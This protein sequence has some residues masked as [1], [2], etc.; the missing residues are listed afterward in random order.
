MKFN[1][2][3]KVQQEFMVGDSAFI[4]NMFGGA[5]LKQISGK[6]CE[7]CGRIKLRNLLVET[8]FWLRSITFVICKKVDGLFA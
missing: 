5:K 7:R 8:S 6:S 3:E 1:D 4:D 2:V